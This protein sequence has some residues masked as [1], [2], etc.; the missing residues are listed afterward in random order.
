MLDWK[1]ILLSL[2][3]LLW[4]NKLIEDK[5]LEKIINAFVKKGGKINQYY[6]IN[7]KRSPT[8]VFYKKWYR[9]KNIRDAI[10]R[11]LAG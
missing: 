8:L 1:P 9:G 5:S 4:Y 10:T 11:A 2:T 3:K 7:P 6:L